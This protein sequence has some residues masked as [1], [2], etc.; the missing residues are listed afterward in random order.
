MEAEGTQ[1]CEKVSTIVRYFETARPELRSIWFGILLLYS[2]GA[3]GRGGER[4]YPPAEDRKAVEAVKR[5]TLAH[6]NRP[7]IAI[8]VDKAHARFS[9]GVRSTRE[10]YSGTA[11][12]VTGILFAEGA[13]KARRVFFGAEAQRGNGPDAWV[14]VDAIYYR[15]AASGRAF[16]DTADLLREDRGR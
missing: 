6:L 8:T 15:L 11:N 4:V 5:A 9:T 12:K 1:P 7:I 3:K 16:S 2:Y 14:P 13:E 10:Y